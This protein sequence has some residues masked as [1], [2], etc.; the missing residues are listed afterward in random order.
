MR[1]VA[2]W[3]GAG[4][5]RQEQAGE[6][7]TVVVA[8][9]PPPPPPRK[10]LRAAVRS[11]ISRHHRRRKR[12]RPRSGESGA[13]VASGL[14]A[15]SRPFLGAVLPQSRPGGASAAV[16][17]LHQSSGIRRVSPGTRL[18]R[19]CA[20]RRP[21][22]PAHLL[23]RGDGEDVAA[24]ATAALPW[25]LYGAAAPGSSGKAASSARQ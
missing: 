16:L 22:S 1:L 14:K 4:V 19:F 2:K 3:V 10:R 20:R 17:F 11:F 18:G 15:R 12:V 7:T 9:P 21:L 13:V 24:A 8:P 23:A 5:L 6:T 25:G